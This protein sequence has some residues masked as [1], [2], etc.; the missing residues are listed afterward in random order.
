MLVIA[1][2]FV[3]VYVYKI[4]QSKH[5]NANLNHVLYFIQVRE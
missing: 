4:S 5:T 1:H 2:V 3:H